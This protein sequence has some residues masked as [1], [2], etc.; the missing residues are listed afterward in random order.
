M[1]STAYCLNSY[2]RK[3]KTA[4]KKNFLLLDQITQKMQTTSNSLHFTHQQLQNKIKIKL[5]P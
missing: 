3:K 1:L 2:H 5:L 4:I